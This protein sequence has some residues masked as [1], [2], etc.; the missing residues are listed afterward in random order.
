MNSLDITPTPRVLRTLGDIPFA[1]WQ[2]IAELVDN[3]ID[4]FQQSEKQGCQI[5]KPRIDITWSSDAVAAK[6]KELVVSDNGPGMS[7]ATLQKAVK[8]GYTSNDPINNLGLFGMGFNIATAK[9]GDHTSVLSLEPNSN[10]WS[11]IEIDF[12]ALI[13]SQN[14]SAPIISAP[15]STHEDSGTKIICRKIKANIIAEAKAKESLI[16]KQLETIYTPILLAGKINIFLQ[17]KILR[18]RKRCVWDESRYVI[19][20]GDQIHAIQHIDVNLGKSYFSTLKNRYLSSDESSDLDI[21]ISRGEP[22]PS[23]VIERDRRLKGWIGIQRFCD[24]SEFGIDFIRNGRKILIFDKSLFSFE[25]PDTLTN[26]LEYPVELGSTLGGRIIGELHVDFLIPTYQ[27]N[28][29]DPTD[30][31]WR[32]VVEG[33]RGAGPLLPQSRSALGFD[34]VNSSPLGQ[35]F[36]AYRRADPGTKR[37]AIPNATAKDLYQKFLNGEAEYQTDE[38]WY[39]IAKEIDQNNSDG[40]KPVT[41][42]NSGSNDSD[43]VDDYLSPN[44]TTGNSVEATSAVKLPSLPQNTTL[45]ILRSNSSKY[46]YLTGSY[47]YNNNKGLDVTAFRLEKGEIRINGKRL[48][49]HLI[50]DG[51]TCE[52]FFDPTHLLFTEF[53]VSEKQVLLT[54]LSEKFRIRD[55][56]AQQ[57][58]LEALFINHLGDERI[59]TQRLQER[60]HALLCGIRERLPDLLLPVLSEA[61]AHVLEVDSDGEFLYK[62][63]MQDAPNLLAVYQSGGNGSEQALN[64]ISDSAVLRLIKKFPHLLFDG[65]L[66]QIPY[67]SINMASDA[68]NRRLRDLAVSTVTTYLEDLINLFA[69]QRSSKWQMMRVC[70]TLNYLEEIIS[71]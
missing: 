69:E 8:A 29:F 30:P 17:G 6:D 36:N 25:N 50:Q 44:Q 18:P 62:R 60:A 32:L 9:I 14:F 1:L 38:K 57:D 24:T 35:L 28:G 54:L 45:Q 21:M 66:F 20:K 55:Q 11:G 70:N 4:A 43:T 48:A 15:K 26:N 56:V 5:K 7:L 16:R 41:P 59:N 27:K 53:P 71:R 61:N 64:F 67:S 3:S 37:L 40:S 33:I 23:G 12:E 34:V 65:H 39:E 46:Q 22:L 10:E 47:S 58:A 13:K 42:V 31:S 19:Y 63:L 2:C 49:C 51:V 52:F 68:S